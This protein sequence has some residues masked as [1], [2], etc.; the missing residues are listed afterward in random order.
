MFLNPKYLLFFLLTISICFAQETV[1]VTVTGYG[2]D[3]ATA[4]KS[5]IQKAVRKALG[6][7]VDAETITNDD[8][9]IHV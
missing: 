6:E 5:A 3:P 7:F 9:I 8:E 1:S 2:T 4:E